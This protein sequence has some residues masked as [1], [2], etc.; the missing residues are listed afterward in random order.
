[1]EYLIGVILAFVVSLS[2]TLVGLDRDRAFYPVV[3][4]V[5]ALLYVL[6][7]VEV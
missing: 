1:M 7:G 3:I 6:T 4:M 2:A 5:I